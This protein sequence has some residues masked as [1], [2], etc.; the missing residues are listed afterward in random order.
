MKHRCV[1][2]WRRFQ[3]TMLLYLF[4][5]SK[6]GTSAKTVNSG[7]LRKTL[8][9]LKDEEVVKAVGRHVLF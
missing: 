4:Q 8:S 6:P 9:E 7:K 1:N 3:L 2:D 5:E